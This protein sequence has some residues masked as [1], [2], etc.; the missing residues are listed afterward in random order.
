M[1]SPK[2]RAGGQSQ[3]PARRSSDPPARSSRSPPRSSP[4]RATPAR[5]STGSP[6]RP[7]PTKRMIYYYFGGKQQLYVAVLER[8]YAG[9]REAEQQID[10]E[11]L[12]PVAA[13]RRLAELTF[14]HHESNPDFIRLVSIE[15]IHRAEHIA[16]S[17]G[18]TTLNN[19][20]IELI[21]RILD[22]GRAPELFRPRRRRGRRPHDDQRILCLQGGQPAHVRR[23]LRPRPDRA[24]HCATTTARCS[25]TWSSGTSP[26]TDTFRRPRPQPT[27]ARLVSPCRQERSAPRSHPARRPG[28]PILAL[29]TSSGTRGCQSSRRPADRTKLPA[30]PF[31]SHGRSMPRTRGGTAADDRRRSEIERATPRRALAAAR[32]TRIDNC[33]RPHLATTVGVNPNRRLRWEG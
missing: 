29:I 23:D 7:A 28:A 20:A 22:R 27:S 30:S 16:Q 8:A 3:T 18:S 17:S 25:P 31:K 32:L 9:I 19:P 33:D 14:D 2:S 5:A 10:V 26:P 15:N 24:P 4:T 21:A 13:I 6:R 12:D 1:A 11:H